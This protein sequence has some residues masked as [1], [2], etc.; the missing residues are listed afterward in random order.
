MKVASV[1]GARPQF[2]KASVV[3]AEIRKFH[4]EVLIHTG[5]HYDREMS[6]V[7]FDE[8][9]IPEPDFN[10]AIGSGS[11]GAQ[12]GAMLAAIESVLLEVEPNVVVVYG[13][14][15]S[16]L[17]ASLAASKLRIPVAH[18]EA[19]LRSF[20]RAMPEEINRVLT[21]HLSAL[22][23][24][25]SEVGVRNLYAEGITEG[26]HVVGD[27]MAAA[28]ARARGNAV[29]AARLLDTLG[30]AP[31]R[32]SVATVHRQ[33]NVESPVR[34]R[35]ILAALDRLAQPVLFPA[36]PRTRAAIHDSGLVTGP[37]VHLTA[38]LGYADMISLQE[39]ARLV[40][41]DSGGMQKE[42]YW[43]G[44]PCLTLRDETEW[45]ETVQLGWNVLVGANTDR[46]VAR[47]ADVRVPDARPELY[48]DPESAARCAQLINS[49]SAQGRGLVRHA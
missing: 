29:R 11:H 2:I 9:G 10:L 30:I 19:G 22:L 15:N 14:T 3:S 32:Y 41:T 6:D 12:T 23:L 20:N 31:K 33:E 7:F 1:V 43:L 4:D 36:H 34:L 40:L 28:V 49:A 39:N 26:V 48:G 38:P 18:V 8:L 25:S 45:V 35:A 24:C 46:I 42:A 47:A 44:V 21:D 16:T 13:D 27:V 37:N 5:Q 17:A